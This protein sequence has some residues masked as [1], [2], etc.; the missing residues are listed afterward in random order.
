MRHREKL[1][2]DMR[3]KERK[4]EKKLKKLEKEGKSNK[5]KDVAEVIAIVWVYTSILV[6]NW[7][8]LFTCNCVTMYLLLIYLY[9][10][11]SVI[12]LFQLGSL[13]FYDGDGDGDGNENVIPKYN[14]SFV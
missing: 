11:T 14:F 9:I 1:R 2:Q 13:R 7:F 12:S 6:F 10:D 3:E 4:K 8:Y 5:E